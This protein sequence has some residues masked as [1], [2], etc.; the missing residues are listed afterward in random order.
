MR[1][2]V[3]PPTLWSGFTFRP[4]DPPPPTQD[5][6]VLSPLCW[7][8]GHLCTFA[9]ALFPLPFAASAPNDPHEVAARR[10]TDILCSSGDGPPLSPLRSC[11]DAALPL[12][13]RSEAQSRP[14]QLSTAELRPGCNRLTGAPVLGIGGQEPSW[15]EYLHLRGLS[16][17]KQTRIQFSSKH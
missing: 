3:I 13:T 15:E 8:T 1:D 17:H 5:P 2:R 9:L 16:H 6:K 14:C 7:G 12:A 11:E 10:G 4:C